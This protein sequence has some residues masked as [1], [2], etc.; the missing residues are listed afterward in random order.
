MLTKE[1][2]RKAGKVYHDLCI[3]V[4]GTNIDNFTNQTERVSALSMS[5]YII[6]G[7]HPLILTNGD[8][9]NIV[10]AAIHIQKSGEQQ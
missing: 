2:I 4:W 1:T 5:Y 9:F 6:H 10:D 8:L 7:E 3:H